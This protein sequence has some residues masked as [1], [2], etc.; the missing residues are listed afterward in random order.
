VA[1]LIIE[2]SLLYFTV[3]SLPRQG[4]EMLTILA[5]QTRTKPRAFVFA[6]RDRSGHLAENTLRT[7]LHGLGFKVTAYGSRSLI[8]DLLNEQGFNADA[9]ERQL[10]HLETNKVRATYLRSFRLTTKTPASRRRWF[11]F[12]WRNWERTN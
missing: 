12:A 11:R 5:A 7:R 4:V 9:I 8:T 1:T 3:K 10:D 6:S 2:L